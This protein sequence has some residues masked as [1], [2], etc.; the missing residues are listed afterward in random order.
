MNLEGYVR[1]L[2]LVAEMD[3]LQTRMLVGNWNLRGYGECTVDM[4]ATAKHHLR[5]HFAVVGI[6]ER[7]D[8]FY[9]TLCRR[10][11]W[12]AALYRKHQ[13]TR[14]RPR[15]DELDSEILE[16][17]RDYNQFDI[18]LYK[19]ASEL[20]EAQVRQ[21]DSSFA[22]ELRSFRLRIVLYQLY[23]ELRRHSVRAYLRQWLR[24]SPN[25]P[26]G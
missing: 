10:L 17:I 19:Y 26:A 22:A 18:Q 5:M 1:H 8:E 3:N 11:G 25:G 12:P 9:L 6:T 2:A 4:L 20:F 16:L 23:W 21:Q 24:A 14:K 15:Q 7:F 13:V